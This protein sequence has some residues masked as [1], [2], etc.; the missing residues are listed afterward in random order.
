I[1]TQIFSVAPSPHQL[2]LNRACGGLKLL[3]G[4]T[5]CLPHGLNKT[6]IKTELIMKRGKIREI[7]IRIV[8]DLLFL[9]F[10]ILVLFQI[11]HEKY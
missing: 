7:I 4:F 10:L 3:F 1:E 8:I 2:R 9:L 5:F 6:K 11:K